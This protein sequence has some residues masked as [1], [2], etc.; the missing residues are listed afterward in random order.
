[1]F[2]IRLIILIALVSAV[3]FVYRK[4]TVPKQGTT[5]PPPPTAA[6]MKKCS[7]CGVHLPSAEAI[8]HQGHFFCCQDHK[9]TYLNEHPND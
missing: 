3:I 2:I 6:S 8:E 7:Q 5:A 1:M 9:N 4:L